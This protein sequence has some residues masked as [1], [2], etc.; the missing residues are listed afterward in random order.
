LETSKLRKL[1]KES[2]LEYFTAE[3]DHHKQ[4]TAEISPQKKQG[5]SP[6]TI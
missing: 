2:K 4:F 3:Q 6:Q 1:Q 5:N